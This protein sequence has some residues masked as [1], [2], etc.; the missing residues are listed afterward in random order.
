MASTTTNN[1]LT[2][3]KTTTQKQRQNQQQIPNTRTKPTII[4][5]TSYKHFI[6]TQHKNTQTII[7]QGQTQIK[8]THNKQTKQNKTKQKPSKPKTNHT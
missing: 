5:D 1:A 4:H 8:Q 6:H 7:K 3:H 2:K